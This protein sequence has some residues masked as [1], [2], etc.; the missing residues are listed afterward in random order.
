MTEEPLVTPYTPGAL[1]ERLAF[2]RGTL[3]RHADIAAALPD[4]TSQ[5]L[6]EAADAIELA[7]ESGDGAIVQKAL[8]TAQNYLR[9]LH[10]TVSQPGLWPE[11]RVS[12][13]FQDLR[14]PDPLNKEVA[15]VDIKTVLVT[16]SMPRRQMLTTL[17]FEHAPGAVGYRLRETRFINGEDV[18]DEMIASLTPIFR[19]V[20][21]PA[22]EHRLCIESR[23]DSGI[24][25]S[26]E[27][28]ITVPEKL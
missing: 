25:L 9:Q 4:T 10:E 11:E 20:R 28:T 21:I 13:V 2:L 23:D 5:H 1:L 16:Y 6:R 8:L 18:E 3:K 7:L 14:F 24:A 19:R 12:G 22:G 17:A 26:E 15:A 27:F